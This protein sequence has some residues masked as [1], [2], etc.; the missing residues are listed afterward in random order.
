MFSTICEIIQLTKVKFNRKI[1]KVCTMWNDVV[2]DQQINHTN[3]YCSY[4]S[5]LVEIIVLIEIIKR[6]Q[7]QKSG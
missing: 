2:I 4:F 3:F 1:V 6:G 7:L 5:Y